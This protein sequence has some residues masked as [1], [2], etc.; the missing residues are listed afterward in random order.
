MLKASRQI[1]LDHSPSLAL[2]LLRAG[3]AVRHF[4]TVASPTLPWEKVYPR[5]CACRRP[6]VSGR[7][8]GWFCFVILGN[9][10]SSQSD[11]CFA[12]ARSHWPESGYKSRAKSW[13][14]RIVDRKRIKMDLICFAKEIMWLWLS[15]SSFDLCI[16]Y[17]R[18]NRSKRIKQYPL[19]IT[20]A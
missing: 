1:S 17:D 15:V 2:N 3:A 16:A 19:A 18:K 9:S 6:P 8:S 7:V 12:F 14:S 20:I 10:R 4:S 5:W 13:V 11:W